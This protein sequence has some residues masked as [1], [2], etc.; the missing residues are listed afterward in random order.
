M[1]K[2]AWNYQSFATDDDFSCMPDRAAGLRLP[3]KFYAN[4]PCL[5]TMCPRKNWAGPTGDFSTCALNGEQW[6]YLSS[7]DPIP[8][9]TEPNATTYLCSSAVPKAILPIDPINRSVARDTYSYADA[10]CSGDYDR[11]GQCVAPIFGCMTPSSLNFDSSATIAGPAGSCVQGRKGCTN[12]LA[13][14]Y[15]PIYN[16][17]DGS[18]ELEVPGCTI[19]DS[20]NFNSLATLCELASRAPAL[21]SRTLNSLH[22]SS[23]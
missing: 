19:E 10:F 14:N 2:L 13:L 18:C 20:I 12:S 22:V 1:R 11:W 23:T 16:M 5:K 15:K 7:Y 17:D 8:P 21:S 3:S 4:K 6:R 9:E